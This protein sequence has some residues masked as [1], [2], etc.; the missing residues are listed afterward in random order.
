MYGIGLF[1]STITAQT[2]SYPGKIEEVK[3]DGFIF[4]PRKARKPFISC[5]SH[6]L[7]AKGSEYYSV[8]MAGSGLGGMKR[9][10]RILLSEIDQYCQKFNWSAR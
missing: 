10:C 4:T 7:I 6:K 1:D 2:G 3:K 5:L 9:P 8:F